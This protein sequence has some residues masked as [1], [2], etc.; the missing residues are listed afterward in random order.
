MR[1]KLSLL[2]LVFT[3]LCGTLFAASL[4]L[5][6][7]TAADGDNFFKGTTA[8]GSAW[9]WGSTVGAGGSGGLNFNAGAN[10]IWILKGG[11]VPQVGKAYRLRVLYKNKIQNGYGGIGFT[12]QSGDGVA[13]LSIY[14]APA[15]A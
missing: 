7:D 11:F 5:N 2:A 4:T 10:N 1:F 9:T 3:Q 15:N 8:A 6:F 13:N 14:A 12:T